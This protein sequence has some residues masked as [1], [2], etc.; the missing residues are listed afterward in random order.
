M[1]TSIQTNL[2]KLLL[3][4][5]A[6]VSSM[7]FMEYMQPF[8]PALYLLG[9]AVLIEVGLHW[10][11]MTPRTNWWFGLAAITVDIFLLIWNS[12]SQSFPMAASVDMP[13]PEGFQLRLRLL[14]FGLIAIC[15]VAGM[16]LGG[17]RAAVKDNVSTGPAVTALRCLTAVPLLILLVW[18]ITRALKVFEGVKF[19]LFI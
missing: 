12:W 19:Q 9:V 6:A 4:D 10:R 17:V 8:L 14:A 11:E 7:P 13:G 1:I 5:T 3:A 15:S 16:V 2:G 18:H